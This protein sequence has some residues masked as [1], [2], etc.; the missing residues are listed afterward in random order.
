MRL[1]NTA[2]TYGAILGTVVAGMFVEWL[3][4][5]I[6][7]RIYVADIIFVRPLCFVLESLFN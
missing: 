5:W 4:L 3:E 1:E 7:Q 6:F 2:R